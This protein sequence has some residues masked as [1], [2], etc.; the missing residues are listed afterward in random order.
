VQPPNIRLSPAEP[1]ASNE[2]ESEPQIVRLQ[3]IEEARMK[4]M[5]DIKLMF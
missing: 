1:D 3:R 2:I 4:E 5:S